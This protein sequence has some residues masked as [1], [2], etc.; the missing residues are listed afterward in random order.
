[1]FV[2]Y[3]ISDCLFNQLYT[4]TITIIDEFMTW[5]KII[6]LVAQKLWISTL[7]LHI[8]VIILE[9]SLLDKMP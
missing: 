3:K 7:A 5:E 4:V 2:I 9:D 6:R 8:L 1:M